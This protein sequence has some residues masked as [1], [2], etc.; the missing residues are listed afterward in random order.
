MKKNREENDEDNED[1]EDDEEDDKDEDERRKHA[2]I[3]MWVSIRVKLSK[4]NNKIN[5]PLH[6]AGGEALMSTTL[7]ATTSDQRPTF[8]EREFWKIKDEYRANV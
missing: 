6:A 8:E 7:L 3:L 2:R 1:D 4:W 5:L